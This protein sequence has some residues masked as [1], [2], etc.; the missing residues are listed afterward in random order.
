MK[1][2]K[3]TGRSV[4]IEHEV[5]FLLFS[6]HGDTF[7]SRIAPKK[8]DYSKHFGGEMLESQTFLVADV[9][10]EG[11]GHREKITVTE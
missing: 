6:S 7:N 4:P 2:W 1:L 8:R 3:R 11:L 5:I 10:M 9:E